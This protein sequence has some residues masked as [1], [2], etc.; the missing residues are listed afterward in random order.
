MFRWVHS[1]DSLRVA[2]EISKRALQLTQTIQSGSTEYGGESAG[3]GKPE[4]AGINL[5]LE[6]NT[7]G[8]ETKFGLQP[9]DALALAGK[10]AALPGIKLRGLMTMAPLVE[11]PED[12]RPCFQR[13]R[14]LAGAIA[15]SG[16]PGVE[17]RHLSMGMT[18]DFEIAVEEGATLVRI[19]TAIFGPR[20]GQPPTSA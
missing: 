13:L 14:Q 1:I 8:E 18:N 17:M 11:N 6:V 15:K 12:A 3:V 19:G 10:A 2:E 5:L 9:E 4:E 7:S 16:L 20:P